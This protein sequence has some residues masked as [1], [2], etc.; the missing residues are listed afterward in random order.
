MHAAKQKPVPRKRFEGQSIKSPITGEEGELTF[1]RVEKQLRAFLSNMV[2]LAAFG[3]V[4]VAV[5]LISQVRLALYEYFEIFGFNYAANVVGVINACVIMAFNAIYGK[6]GLWLTRY[7]NHRDYTS[8]LESYAV[9][10]G[11]GLGGIGG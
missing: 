8:F 10:V 7:E 1:S 4:L 5:I 2:S 11:F 3:A 6:V 9:K